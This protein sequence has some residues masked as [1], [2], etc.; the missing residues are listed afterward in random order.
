SDRGT[1]FTFQIWRSFQKGLGT[2]VKV[3]IT[4][5]RWNNNYHLSIHMDPLEALYERRCRSPIGVTT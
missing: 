2:R 1:Q 5:H 3:S 4:L